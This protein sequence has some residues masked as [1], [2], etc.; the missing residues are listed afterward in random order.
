LY[1][2]SKHAKERLKERKLK[3]EWIKR[4][5]NNPQKVGVDP[6]DP[7]VH[8]VWK[9]ITEMDNRVL[10]VCYNPNKQPIVIVTL[11]FDRK[12]KGKL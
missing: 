5:L 7:S 6:H 2:L 9:E 1:I 3:E 12:M 11:H 8:I 4:A 10:K